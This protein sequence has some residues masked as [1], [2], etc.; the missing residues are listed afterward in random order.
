MTS[1]ASA[2]ASVA[3]TALPERLRALR[4]LLA[5][6]ALEEDDDSQL[7]RCLRATVE[8]LD[9][10]LLPRTAGGVAH[11]VVGV[12]GPNNA[13]KSALFNALVGRVVSPSS[14]SGGATRRL[15]GAAR[16]E[17]I[18][19]LEGEPTLAQFPLTRATPGPDGVAS[20]IEPGDDAAELL[21]VPIDD[22]EDGLLLV[23]TP[24]FDSILATNR[25]ASEALL[26]VADLVIVVVTRHTYQNREVVE[27]LEG[28]LA[29]GRPWI[30]VYNESLAPETTAEHG[31][32]LADDLG[33]P[34][35]ATFH[36]PFDMGV[37]EGQ[38]PLLP[39]ALAEAPA[40]L[41]VEP[42]VG[43]DRWL[44][45]LESAAE[46]KRRA[47][48]AS[49]GRLRDE[50]RQLGTLLE[51]ERA[52]AG[53]LLERARG[54][55][56]RLGGKVAGKAM[57]MG[58]FLEAFRT[59]LDRR[60]ST[61]Q[62][63]VRGALRRGRMALQGLVSRVRGKR[64]PKQGEGGGDAGERRMVDA[65]RSALEPLW[66]PFFET[67][68]EG[69]DPARATTRDGARP[70][71][72]LGLELDGELA[73]DRAAVARE[74]ALASLAAD[75]E[76]LAEFER[77]CEELIEAELDSAGGEWLLQLAVDAVHILPVIAA[78]VV[79]V[80][81]GGLG[82]DVAVGGA[83]AL[84]TLLAERVSRLLGTQVAWRA[85]EGWQHLRGARIAEVVLEAALPR[86]S[87]RLAR[88]VEQRGALAASLLAMR[89]E[90]GWEPARPS[91]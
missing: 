4:S 33:E 40:A 73:P 1:S 80:H 75:P 18:A 39:R 74:R 54:H 41:S 42:G 85:R 55:A 12:V 66:A 14:P 49:L 36:A 9:R 45:S 7:A 61:V 56:R 63:R 65:E 81:T 88:E 34:P 79:I 70:A 43:I 44:W 78:G 87:A 59:V 21:L 31:R 83:G 69:L 91:A 58:P 50:L 3:D 47:M 53:E 62:R 5:G 22:L 82:A 6:A 51:T 19:R 64:A 17:L 37:T 24:D 46:L 20:A 76:V 72:A 67:L 35:A 11:L 57:P 90:I 52:R 26:R 29:H 77:V 13:G 60:P 86:S 8:R 84:S 71:G 38:R 23:D 89:K 16:P 68:A 48:A 32:K 25:R 28:W 10:D 30:L 2:T 15:V 27:F